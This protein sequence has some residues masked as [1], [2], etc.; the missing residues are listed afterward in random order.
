M[1]EMY[2]RFPKLINLETG[3]WYLNES[4]KE[5]LVLEKMLTEAEIP[6]TLHR[7]LDGWQ[8]IY[9]EE[10]EKRVVDAIEHYGSYGKDEDLLEI[11]GLLTPEEEEDNSV[12]GY[13]SA[14][15]VFKRIWN[16]HYGI[17]DKTGKEFTLD[18]CVTVPADM[19]EEQFIDEFLKLIE[20]KDWFYGG[21][22]GLYEE[23]ET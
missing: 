18:G 9:P 12:L 17:S 19:T 7:L 22:I 20:S 5:I 4:Y 1:C 16:H 21:S 11:M 10:G 14:E 13:L 3:E 15:E 8:V 23:K 6:H 2:D